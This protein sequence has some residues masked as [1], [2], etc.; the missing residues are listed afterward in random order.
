MPDQEA[1]LE[2]LRNLDSESRA[3][4]KKAEDDLLAIG[5]SAVD[6]I[7]KSAHEINLRLLS[8]YQPDSILQALQH[9]IRVL[10]LLRSVRGVQMVSASL[11]D[12][13]EMIYNQKAAIHRMQSAFIPDATSISYAYQRLSIGK[14]LHRTAASALVRIGDEAERQLTEHMS[15]FSP[16]A[17]KSIRQAIR[18]IRFQRFCRKVIGIGSY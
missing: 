6:V 11:A 3:T 2:L 10:G 18:R 8:G 15:S 13:S 12:S 14:R 16:V 4:R 17:Q 9:R 1:I 5:E 7:L